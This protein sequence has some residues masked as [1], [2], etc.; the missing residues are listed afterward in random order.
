MSPLTAPFTPGLPPAGAAGD[1]VGRD[2]QGNVYLLRWHDVAKGW[3]ALGW[4]GAGRAAM[5]AL[6]QPAGQDQ[7]LIIGYAR[8]SGCGEG[9]AYGIVDP[10]YARVFTIARCIAWSEG[11]ALAMHGSFTRDLDL[12]AVPWTD[13]ATEAEHLVRRIA[14]NLDE[15]DLL[16]KDPKAK[17]QATQRPHGRQ[18]WTLTFKAFGD[19]R[20]VDISVMPRAA[21]PAPSAEFHGPFGHLVGAIGLDESHWR[22]EDNP[23]GEPGYFSLPMF[24]QVDPFTLMQKPGGDQ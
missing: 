2:A 4:V 20:F 14:G 16:V 24:T 3:E 22:I 19:P 17:S 10:D 18:S 21:A 15:L 6:R 5:P 11:Y 8:I 7:G 12:L 13:R 1:F 23:C 9:Q